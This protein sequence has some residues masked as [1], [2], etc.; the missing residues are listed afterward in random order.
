MPDLHEL[1]RPQL[2]ALALVPGRPLVVTD[3]DEVLFFFLAGFEAYLEDNGHY[4]D[5]ASFALI[6]NIKVTATAE[7]ATAEAAKALLDGFFRERTEAMVPVP[8]AAAALTAL[9]R[10][11]QIVVLSN[12][13]DWAREARERALALH[14]MAFPV[15]VN[16]GLKGA[17][18]RHMAERVG[19]PVFFLDDIPR[20]HMSVAL[21][22]PAV[23]RLH[24]VAD[25]RLQKLIG[26]AEHCTHRVDDWAEARR[27]IEDE[28]DRTGY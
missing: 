3:A 13:P 15:V 6:G 1:V 28:L 21:A 17:A 27:L 25:S 12:L 7:M 10:R 22:A 23:M 26:P 5:L 4:L 20:N 8:G 9:S 24:F 16:T 2:E 19:A 18:V 11:A 14:G